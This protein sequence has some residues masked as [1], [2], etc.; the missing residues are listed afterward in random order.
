MTNFDATVD[1]ENDSDLECVLAD[2]IGRAQLEGETVH[3][4]VRADGPSCELGELYA[5]DEAIPA[6]GPDDWHVTGHNVS[7]LA[8]RLRA[9]L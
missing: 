9:L 7:Q 3:I 6:L 8:S 2:A 1:F 4:V 5:S